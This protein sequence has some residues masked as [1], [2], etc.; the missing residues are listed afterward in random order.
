M[1]R[2]QTQALLGSFQRNFEPT[3]SGIFISGNLMKRTLEKWKF[4]YMV[5]RVFLNAMLSYMQNGLRT[6]HHK[7]PERRSES[8]SIVVIL[9]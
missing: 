1:G 3:I 7:N 4:V 8:A 9:N 5:L 2:L 6:Y